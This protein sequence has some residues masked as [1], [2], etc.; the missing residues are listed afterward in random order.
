MALSHSLVLGSARNEPGHQLELQPFLLDSEAASR[1]SEFEYSFIF[2]G[3]RYQYGFAVDRKRVLREYLYASPH[4]VTKLYFDRSLDDASEVDTYKFGA[5]LKGQNQTIRGLTRTNQLFLSVAA[6]SNHV[7]LT[8]PYTWFAAKLSGIQA[9]LAMLKGGVDETYHARISA[10]LRMSDVGITDYTFSEASVAPVQ[11][12]TALPKIRLQIKKHSPDGET[13]NV[14]VKMLHPSEGGDPVELD[15]TDE[16]NGTFNVFLL[17][18]SLLRTLDQGQTLFVDE[19]DA[20]K[21]PLLV[22]SLVELFH[23]PEINRK[24]AQLIFNTH[25]TSLLDQTLFRRDQIWFTEK[26]AAG[27]AHLYSLLEY[28]PRKG[29]SLAKGY[30]QG[31][32]GAIPFL[33]DPSLLAQENC[34]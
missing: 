18:T 34:S 4:G 21:H 17:A 8:A 20:S 31:R 30:L 15:V 22:R 25:D 10:L 23:N 26:D 2:E 33:G 5:S 9:H 24:N 28:S 32:Y 7:M 29:E 19:L 27:A 11:M 16:S 6:T 12:P 1:P 14:R 13:A 3:V